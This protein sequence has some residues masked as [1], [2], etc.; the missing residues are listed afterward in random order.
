MF[1]E[2][3]RTDSLYIPGTEIRT[4]QALA[5]LIFVFCLAMLIYF[6]IKKPTKPLYVKVNEEKPEAEKAEDPIVVMVKDLIAK[7]K[8]KKDNNE[9]NNK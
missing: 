7:I 4:S 9:E 3:L 1:I 5:L 8:S 2:G 6:F